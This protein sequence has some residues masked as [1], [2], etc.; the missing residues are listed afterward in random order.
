VSS[1][2]IA[3]RRDYL[4]YNHRRQSSEPIYLGQ[5]DGRRL[6]RSQ[7]RNPHINALLD[8]SETLPVEIVK[9]GLKE[10]E[11]WRQKVG[12]A[13]AL[14][15]SKAQEAKAK[16]TASQGKPKSPEHC[17]ELGALHKAWHARRPASPGT[18]KP[19]SAAARSRRWREVKQQTAALNMGRPQ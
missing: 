8:S 2:Y 15:A 1:F 6:F 18:S 5:G 17:V 12:L 11:A 19:L 4:A 3:G 16:L 9:S 10:G 14:A 13:K 7:R